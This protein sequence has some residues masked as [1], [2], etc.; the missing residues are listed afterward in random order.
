V[1]KAEQETTIR[2]AA[3]E[4]VVSLWTAQAPMRRKLERAGYRPTKVSTIAG[5]P[6]GWFFKIPLAEFRWRVGGKRRSM[7]DAQRQAAGAR[8]SRVRSRTATVG[9]PMS[10][11]AA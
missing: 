7:T 10:M 1:T 11:G 6:V 5:E 9:P 3:D 8:L 4:E 2:W